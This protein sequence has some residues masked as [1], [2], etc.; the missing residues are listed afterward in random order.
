VET[1]ALEV[2]ATWDSATIC[3]KDTED[4]A[5]LVETKAW[6]WVLRVEVE[7]IVALASAHKDAKGLVWKIALLEGELGDACQA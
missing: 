2:A 1:S 3:V 5:T 7:N 4:R 6:E